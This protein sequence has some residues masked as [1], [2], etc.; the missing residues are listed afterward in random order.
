MH[1]DE[2]RASQQSGS[3]S[4]QTEPG[5]T[6]TEAVSAARDDASR[7][8]DPLEADR[9]VALHVFVIL[10][11]SLIRALALDGSGEAV[12]EQALHDR[13]AEEL[14]RSRELGSVVDRV[15]GAVLGDQERVDAEL[16]QAEDD[17][18]N[19]NQHPRLE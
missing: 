8:L 10:G 4:W 13:A 17:Y 2:P 3:Q 12:V 1:S 6:S 11:A 9:T 14:L 7:G 18:V 5:R 19:S 15:V 16:S